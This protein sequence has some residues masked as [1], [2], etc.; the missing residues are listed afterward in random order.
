[1]LRNSLYLL[2]AWTWGATWVRNVMPLPAGG[3]L[4]SSWKD[5]L[6]HAQRSVLCHDLLLPKCQ[7]RGLGSCDCSAVDSGRLSE[8]FGNLGSRG[9]LLQG[10]G[11]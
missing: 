1:M 2:S 4:V 10:E 5:R 6:T 8:G 7:L 9:G 3:Q 11:G